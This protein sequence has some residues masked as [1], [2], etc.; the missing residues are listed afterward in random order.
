MSDAQSLNAIIKTLGNFIPEAN[1]I[2]EKD[3][4]KFYGIDP[5]KVCYLRLLLSSSFFDE[6]RIDSDR[7][8]FGFKLE[9]LS[10]ILSR[11]EKEDKVS[12]KVQSG[13]ATV[14]F[15]GFA[16][17]TFNLNSIALSSSENKLNISY[18]FSARLR[19]GL[20]GDI[21]SEVSNVGE[22]ITFTGSENELVISAKG[23]LGETEITLDNRVNGFLGI[24]QGG[25]GKSSHS[26][27]YLEKLS[28]LEKASDVLI[29]SL[30]D[31]M[32][33]RLKY[34]LPQSGYYEIYIAPRMD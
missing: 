33:L 27:E 31:N 20:F 6:Y 11:T 2:A 7:E 5:A 8:E 14:T 30:S 25:L 4:I 23:D 26:V 34:E 32:P 15:D 19:S 24:E 22:V 28:G 9:D 1:F 21:I 18:Q 12:L 16:E 3:G 29:I 17:R 10:K 13:I